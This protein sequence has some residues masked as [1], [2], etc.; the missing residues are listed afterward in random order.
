VKTT[1]IPVI[2]QLAEKAATIIQAANMAYWLIKKTFESICYLTTVSV[3]EIL[4]LP[5]T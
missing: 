2:H 4:M 3:R 5:F 1:A